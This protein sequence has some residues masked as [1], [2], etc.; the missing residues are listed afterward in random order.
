MD[1][2]YHMNVFWSADDEAWIADVPDLRFCSAF[3][4]TPEIAIAEVQVAI[5]A[6]IESAEADEMPIPAPRYRPL[7][8][9]MP[10]AA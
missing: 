2:R 3:G 1:R 5:A 7:I 8:Y 4:P 6:W 10:F 9:T